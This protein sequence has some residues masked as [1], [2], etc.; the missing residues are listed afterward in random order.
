MYLSNL[1]RICSSV[2]FCIFGFSGVCRAQGVGLVFDAHEIDPVTTVVFGQ[3]L[4]NHEQ[5]VF[6]FADIEGVDDES[7]LWF[8]PASGFFALQIFSVEIPANGFVFHSSSGTYRLFLSDDPN[9]PR[10]PLEGQEIA[11]SPDSEMLSPETEDGTYIYV[12]D[13]SGHVFILPHQGHN[14]PEVLGGDELVIGA[15]E[16]TIEDGVV[17]MYNNLSGHYQ[18]TPES[19]PEV[20]SCL[21]QQCMEI[22]DGAETPW[23]DE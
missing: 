13:T 17:T 6:D 1:L 21:N 8:E 11:K 12:I 20:R 4:P 9:L 2:V 22:A 18:F 14:H 23:E 7:I 16:I 10:L 3:L 5:S 15:G 19:L